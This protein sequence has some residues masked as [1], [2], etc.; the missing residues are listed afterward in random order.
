MDD[1]QLRPAT[2]HDLE[3][4]CA[5]HVR[6]EAHDRVPRVLTLEELHDELD[7]ETVV[8]ETD[9]RVATVADE[10]AGYVYT[11]HL[12]S[13]VRME[14]CYVFAQVDP[15]FRGRGVGR[16]MLAWGVQRA[17]DQLRNSTNDLPKYIRV[18]HYDYVQPAHRLFA[19]AGFT[20][21][22]WFE[23]LLRPL[24]DLP[25][26]IAIDGIEIRPWPEGRDEECRVVKNAAFEDHW[27]STPTSAEKWAHIVR[28][29]SGRPDLSFVAVETATDRIVAVCV[30]Q[31]YESD[32]ELI[33][34]RDGWIDVLGTVEG[35]RGRGLASALIV[36]S[37]HAFARAGFT[38]ASITV[39]GDS[40]TGAAR[41]YRSL[42]FEQ[43]QRTITHEIQVN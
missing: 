26:R 21:I 39:D 32:D 7:D 20:A 33:G 14:R 9:V 4:L 8:L 17:G 28:G 18:D 22:R 30:N 34:R 29:S 40:P 43:R 27:G 11:V 31:R 19:S 5:L 35:W 16:T 25:D 23:E 42:G 12:P 2:A 41:L 1:I 3:A 6:S 10:L 38:H 24:T 37:L 15:Q 36:E 13:D